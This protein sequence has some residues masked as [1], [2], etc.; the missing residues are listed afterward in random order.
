MRALLLKALVLSLLFTAAAAFSAPGEAA[1]VNEHWR[2]P[3]ETGGS[4]HAEDLYPEKCGLCHRDQYN[5]WKNALHSK[6]TGPGLLAQLHPLK[7]PQTAVSCYFCHA[8]LKTQNEELLGENASG[9]AVFLPN[10]SYDERLKLSGVNCAACHVRS[11]GVA[12]P[13]LSMP[14]A[15]KQNIKAEHDSVQ[16]VFFE[17][18]EFCAACHQLDNGYE[19]NGRILVN[20]Y[21]EWKESEYAKNKITCQS[22]HM[23]G[24]RHLFRGVHDQEMVKGGLSFDLQSTDNPESV[25]ATLKITNSGV[26]HF[27]PTY[28]TPL[29]VISGFLTDSKGNALKGTLMEAQIGR[30]V[31][32]DLE[33]ELFDTRIPPFRSFE[34]NYE[35]KRVEKAGQLVLEVRVYPDEFYQRFFESA[36]K[37][38]DPDMKHKELREA[39]RTTSE[40][41]YLL[42]RKVVELR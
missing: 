27:F 34:F 20:T 29:V 36:L 15:R 33:T 14:P 8:P 32:L 37:K 2:R 28:V 35:M 10:S 38:Q 23:P 31:T 22:C 9:E 40:S 39:L 5:D 25:K 26:G 16:N 13:P 24:R 12:G 19:L 3:L 18:A 6:S 30:K 42:F 41:S 11:S 4:V 21:E 7:D 17:E 1:D